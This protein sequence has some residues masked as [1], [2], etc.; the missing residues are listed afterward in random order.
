MPLVA[1]CPEVIDKSPIILAVGYTC[2]SKIGLDLSIISPL[3]FKSTFCFVHLIGFS[4][5]S[6]TPKPE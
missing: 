5:S 3:I 2:G 4:F 6:S 1:P